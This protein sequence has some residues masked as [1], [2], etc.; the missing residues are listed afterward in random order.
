MPDLPSGT[1]TFLFTDI[2]G[3]TALWERDAAIMQQAVTTHDR[4][5]ADAIASHG[6]H[7]YKHV[8]DAV[9]A[10]F[11][12][13]GCALAA[14][15]AAQQALADELWPETG[16]LRVRM[17]LHLGEATPDA[18]GDYHQIAALNRLARL[19]VAGHGGQV[20]LTQAVAR[21]L[22]GL[23]PDGVSLLDL[24]K[25][26]LRDLL[27]PERVS[28]L[29]IA[30]LPS[31]FPPLKSLERH[32]TNLPVQPTALIGRHRE[33]AE[34]HRI[35]TEESAQLVTLTGPGGT[36]KTRL[37]LQVAADLLDHFDDGVFIVD[38]APLTDR[39]LVLST[40]VATLGVREAGGLSLAESLA[41]Y[42]AEKHLL[43]VLDNYE[44]L[45]GAASVAS[46]LLAASPGLRILVTSR[47]P[48]RVRAE[49]EYPVEP[50]ALP[51]LAHLP[52]L[53]QMTEVAAIALFVARAQAV[54]P[55][56]TLT[57]QN[58][59]AVAEICAR[60]DGLPLAIE[61]AAARV[62][63]LPPA[64]LL[65]RLER[66]LPLLTAGTR[67]APVRHRAL[68]DAI[69][70][71]HDLL[72]SASQT[73]FR[74]LGIFVGGCTLEAVEAIV[75]PDA[76]LDVL[77]GLAS[78]V[79]TSL[80]R[81][82]EQANGEPRFT[83][84]ETIREFALEQLAERNEDDAV[85]QRHAAYY[86]DVAE[87]LKAQVP[88]VEQA[89]ALAEFEREHDNFRA[90]LVWALAKE[91]PLGS[92]LAL[93]LAPFWRLHG[94][95]REGRS[96]LERVLATLRLEAPMRLLATEA[97]SVFVSDLGE[98]GQARGLH[99]QVL[100]LARVEGDRDA[101]ATALHNLALLALE[102][103]E[104][105]QAKALLA[106]SLAAQESLGQAVE[107]G[108][109]RMVLGWTRLA[110][111]N[112]PEARSLIEASLGL[113]RETGRTQWVARALNLLGLLALA[114]GD[115][116]GG[117]RLLD[118]SLALFRQVEH[119]IGIA[120]VLID[121]G[122]VAWEHG[123]P[124]AAQQ[125]HEALTLVVEMARVPGMARAIEGIA[126]LVSDRDPLA[127]VRVAGIADSL[128]QSS[129]TRPFPA[130]AARLGRLL[131]NARRATDVQDIEAAWAAGRAL[132]L[133]TAVAAALAIADDILNQARA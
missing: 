36:G 78:L 74:R 39:D 73:L 27:E 123:D 62:K 132:P 32:P 83:M 65:A 81:Q 109:T 66:R 122:W 75:N 76:D 12:A 100:R 10:A 9:Q 25:H 95:L 119:E 82:W 47:A 64:A 31:H 97:L 38:L 43:L 13:P 86:T 60:L 92:R 11:A 54:K 4:L 58:A 108:L 88:S 35:L 44:H 96:W 15:V 30:G 23:L 51:N 91:H 117:R 69:A 112:L 116:A 99:E 14:A 45:L 129:Q 77:G 104:Y 22:D 113:F 125:F 21:Q 1:V 40:I 98:P 49:Q 46:D 110:E 79:D 128:R 101:E 33:L 48:L 57:A 85:R 114:E 87:R 6:G 2:E 56:F 90:G 107:V 19:L 59:S 5:L 94:H 24:G 17:A 8:G 127:A 102:G 42:L 105:A 61:L 52:S 84:L 55:D 71:S 26:R 28:Q 68:R 3:S 106:E 53:E 124:A 72:D 70:W 121:L 37:A 103:G 111:G 130:E 131:D 133:E 126:A 63:L 7:L 50:L 29:V 18:R 115:P 118:E 67:D 120:D 16:P 20:L 80:L 34:L 93:A 89:R 41:A